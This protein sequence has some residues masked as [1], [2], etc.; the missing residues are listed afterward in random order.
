M[1]CRNVVCPCFLNYYDYFNNNRIN[2][3]VG[4]SIFFQGE[5]KKEQL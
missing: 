1:V 2:N 3:L 5:T 4:S